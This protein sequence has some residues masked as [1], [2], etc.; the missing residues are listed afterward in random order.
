MA[1]GSS[2]EQAQ[3]TASV[4]SQLTKSFAGA[5]AVAAQYPQYA[6]EITAAA[7]ESFLQGDQWAYMAGIIAVLLGAAIVFTRFP[8]KDEEEALLARYAAEDAAT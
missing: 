5:E 2:P 7:K 6:T 4:Q 8:K 1:I 3:V